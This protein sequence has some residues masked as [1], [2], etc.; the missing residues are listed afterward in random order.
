MFDKVVTNVIHHEVEVLNLIEG[1]IVLE[2]NLIKDGAKN[3]IKCGFHKSAQ[4]D[5]VK[6]EFL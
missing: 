1:K 3:T 6:C 5:A 2:K 4:S